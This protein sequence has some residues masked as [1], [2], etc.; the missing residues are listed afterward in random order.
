MQLFFQWRSTDLE[1]GRWVDILRQS[2]RATPAI[3]DYRYFSIKVR[4]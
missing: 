1:I 3:A 2:G 4:H